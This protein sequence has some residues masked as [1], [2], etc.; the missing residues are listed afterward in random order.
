M[1]SFSLPYLSEDPH[2]GTGIWLHRK[3]TLVMDDIK[4]FLWLGH[5]DLKYFL[6]YY[7]FSTPNIYSL[8]LHQVIVTFT[9]GIE[10]SQ[11]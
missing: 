8:R 10:N 2:R 4:T 1:S 9:Q 7:I 5:V 3:I 6:T 11:T